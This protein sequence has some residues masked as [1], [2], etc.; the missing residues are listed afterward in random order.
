MPLARTISPLLMA[1]GDVQR[2]FVLQFGLSLLCWG[3]TTWLH[4][5]EGE[6]VD[7]FEWTDL[8]SFTLFAGG[9]AL[10]CVEGAWLARWRAFWRVPW[11]T[12]AKGAPRRW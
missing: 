10:L 2:L 1:D 5:P 11:T 6:T 7:S 8:W 4:L 9:V 3:S 12:A